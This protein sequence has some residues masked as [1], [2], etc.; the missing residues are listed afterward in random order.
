MPYMDLDRKRF[1]RLTVIGHLEI[2][3]GKAHWPCRCECGNTL[4]VRGDMLKCGNTRSCG[5]L[6]IESATKHGHSCS[7]PG[8]PPS[9]TYVSWQA[10]TVRCTDPTDEHY[11]S[12]GGRGVTIC[13]R[14][15]D[16]RNFLEDMGERPP[17]KTLDR[18]PDRDGNYEPG[19]CRWGT[20]GQQAR[21]R[22]DNRM[23]TH[24]GLTLCVADWA[25]RVGIPRTVIQDRLRLK[26]DDEKAVST[27]YRPYKKKVNT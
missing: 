9:R 5:C 25:D 14:W 21:N 26:W 4:V 13:Q 3:R 2:I 23:I 16:F 22:R 8:K 18:F 11:P 12:Y 20:P 6:K 7:R 24:Q 19:N 27:P 15:L 17:G 1:G 10:M